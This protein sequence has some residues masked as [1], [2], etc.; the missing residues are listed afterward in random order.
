MRQGVYEATPTTQS[1]TTV[2]AYPG[3]R[4][5]HNYKRLTL[6]LPVN[7]GDWFSNVETNSLTS[8]IA[9]LTYYCSW[10]RL[11]STNT[12]QG[13]IQIRTVMAAKCRLI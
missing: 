1:V 9:K 12:A 8:R 3:S 10:Y 5:L 4:P 2:V 7:N 11:A 13:I 6:S